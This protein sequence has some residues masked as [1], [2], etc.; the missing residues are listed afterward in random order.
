MNLYIALLRGINVSGQKL[1]KM[2][3]L[4]QMFEQMGFGKVQTYIQ[5][6]NVLFE[7]E[8][9]EAALRL[10]I[11][12]RIEEV[13]GF[14]VTV[15]IR[16]IEQLEHIAKHCP[17]VAN[18]SS[19]IEKV[20]IALLSEKPSEDKIAKLLLCTSEIDEFQLSSSKL[21]VYILCRQS[22]RKSIFTNN[23]LEK[24]L[25]VAATTRNWQTM[26]KLTMLGKALVEEGL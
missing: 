8:E 22:V 14:V 13:F 10:K 7:S 18:P 1:I 24:K 3:D 11:E 23:F 25:G 16:T 21:E 2:V 26:S 17:F 12:Q 6:G 20:Y 5:S 19:Q 4:K 15:V 9:S